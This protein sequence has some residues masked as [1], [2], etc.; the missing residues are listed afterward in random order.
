MV[1]SV[2]FMVFNHGRSIAKNV[3]L[4]MRVAL[5]ANNPDK[6]YRQLS[7][8]IGL[9]V[10]ERKVE[11]PTPSEPILRNLDDIPASESVPVR[12]GF[13]VPHGDAVGFNEKEVVRFTIQYIEMRI[14]LKYETAFGDKT[15]VKQ[16]FGIRALEK[17]GLVERIAH[18]Q[19]N[20]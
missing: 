13:V 14:V 9:N 3:S 17:D 10:S 18:N 5:V 1:L 12:Q 8:T 15:I 11:N 4:E 19:N 7:R 2:E 20:K 6:N 16:T